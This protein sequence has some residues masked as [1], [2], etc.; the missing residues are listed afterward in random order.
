MIKNKICILF[1]CFCFL[2][3]AGLQA[4]TL[5]KPVELKALLQSLEAQFEITFS[6]LDETIK[7]I[8]VT[9]LPE[10]TNLEKYIQ[11]L[12]KETQLKIRPLQ[13]DEYYYSITIQEV[14]AFQ[15]CGYLSDLEDKTPL[16]GVAVIA[17]SLMTLTDE[18][19]YFELVGTEKKAADQV[20]FRRLGYETIYKGLAQFDMDSCLQISLK[21]SL[22]A[23]EEV[24][25]Y[26]YIA[27]GIE[28]RINGA[29]VIQN[30]QL[31]VL[32]G[33][34]D[35]D[36]M[37][38]LQVLPGIQSAA[39]SVSD[40]NIRGGTND[41]NLVLWDGIRMYQTGHFFGLI[42]VFN[43]HFTKQFSLIKN[44]SSASLGGAVS[45]TIDIK[46]ETEPIKAFS[47]AGGLNLLG[48]DLELEIPL[49]KKTSVLLAGR[50]SISNLLQT[51][52]YD[53]YFD[54]AFGDIESLKYTPGD[55]LKG[56][57]KD[58]RYYDLGV[59]FIHKVSEKE[60]WQLS[61]LNMSDDL[62]YQ[63]KTVS[64]LGGVSKLSEI[65]Q[66]STV[67]GLT[68]KKKWGKGWNTQVSG[69]LSHYKLRAENLDISNNQLLKQE[70]EI[71][72]WGVKTQASLDINDS[73]DWTAGYHF[74]ENG[75]SNRDQLNI[76]QFNRRIKDVIRTH[77]F[78]SEGI[79]TSNSGKT[80]VTAGARSNY[81]ESLDSWTIEPRVLINRRL[82]DKWFINLAGE[83]K[84]QTATQIIDLQNDFLGIE[85]RRWV[86][87]ND[88]D[89]PLIKSK[90]ISAGLEYSQDHWLINVEGYHKQVDGIVTSSQAFQNQFELVR[91][92]GSYKTTGIDLLLNYQ[93]D[94]LST[95][96]S[97][98][99]S[100]NLNEFKELLDEEFSSN[101][102]IR[103]FI[104]SG[105]NYSLRMLE[106]S[107][108]VNWHT[109]NP[110]TGP[111]NELPVIDGEINYRFPNSSNLPY[112][113]RIDI[114]AKYKF[115][116]S[117]KIKT[118]IG[119]SVWN[120]TDHYNAVNS[121]FTLS[122]D[123]VISRVTEK[124]LGITPNL[125]LRMIF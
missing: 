92:A 61:V 52:T 95:W 88:D 68:H 112:Y 56:E 90:Q 65:S 83:L 45:G 100:R 36:V 14:N 25:I 70:N 74:D 69:Y 21:Q 81:F 38:S 37:Q 6:Y 11:Y 114:G 85:K 41:Q 93:Y 18:K 64:A 119:L 86:L 103:H 94:K 99:V 107:L 27:Q 40:I 62:N 96:T 22:S 28:K 50:H 17:G 97:Y 102:D 72:N 51:P 76:P 104:T 84:S 67:M 121:Y 30:A 24:I 58:F 47:T 122:Q 15:I 23:L 34:I 98:T 2:Q 91:S 12:E 53:Q 101:I 106:C 105:V 32:P 124:G 125:M 79:Y 73:F 35:E 59:K 10:G 7:N 117:D 39:E 42:S 9:P 66:Q 87:A 120:I 43:P 55:T 113:L 80:V 75:M 111:S 29:Y 54:R 60:D 16:E 48:T 78:F 118:Q 89:I 71:L 19:G 8:K 46:T 110:F 82:T 5:I 109:G 115:L 108:G 49:G 3:V 1:F 116:I 63:E 123:E 31:Q 26:N 4:Q 20:T 57:V 77:A 44:G 13:K 33:I